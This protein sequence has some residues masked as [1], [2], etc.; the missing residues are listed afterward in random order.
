MSWIG[1]FEARVRNEG[2]II[3]REILT[4]YGSSKAVVCTQTDNP[5]TVIWIKYESTKAWN[6]NGA[7]KAKECL[8]LFDV[9]RGCTFL[10]KGCSTLWLLDMVM[11][12]GFG[13]AGGLPV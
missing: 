8:G 13:V 12:H 3:P 10:T 11:R 6:Q 4:V 7:F 2:V 9:S 1:D 5:W